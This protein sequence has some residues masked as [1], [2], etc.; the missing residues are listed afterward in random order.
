MQESRDDLVVTPETMEAVAEIV[1]AEGYGDAAALVRDCA[2]KRKPAP[3]TPGE[4]AKAAFNGRVGSTEE[5][6]DWEAVAEA[7]C[8]GMVPQETYDLLNERYWA[9]AS[10]PIAEVVA[11][12]ERMPNVCAKGYADTNT[13]YI[14][15]T[16]LEKYVTGDGLGLDY[17]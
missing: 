14:I 2:E 7:A 1:E 4:R 3:L 17:E 9:K 8:Q 16:A 5:K 15:K 11:L 6:A 10:I 12:L 13:L